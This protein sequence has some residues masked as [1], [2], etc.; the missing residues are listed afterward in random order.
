MDWQRLSFVTAVAVALSVSFWKP[1]TAEETTESSPQTA[2]GPVLENCFVMLVEEADIPAQE[3]GVLA[4]LKV[5]EGTE[6]RAGDLLAK[7]DDRRA[8]IDKR[9]A[10]DQYASAREKADNDI[11]FRYAT[12]AADV[13]EAAYQAAL[14]ANRR[15]A[16]SVASSE[17][18]K[19]KLEHRRAVLQIEQSRLE[20]STM[21]HEAQEAAAKLEAADDNLRRRKITSPLDGVVVDVR[22]HVGEWV[23]PGDVVLHVVR[24]DRLRVEGFIKAADAPSSRIRGRDVTVTVELAGKAG[25][26]R[27]EVTGKVVFVSPLLQTGGDYRVWAEVNNRQQDGQWLLQPGQPVSMRVQ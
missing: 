22:R 14:D 27:H 21:G 5:A 11:N 3:A 8:E 20:R 17:V 25:K 15:V 9:L 2:A 12:A 19:L 23:Q 6:V 16:N 13:A 1:L 10:A 24:L 7:I 26:E 18:R 4:E